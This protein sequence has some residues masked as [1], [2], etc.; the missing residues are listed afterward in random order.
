MEFATLSRVMEILIN[1]AKS[2]IPDTKTSFPLTGIA[3]EVRQNIDREIDAME[4]AAQAVKEHT[5]KSLSD[6]RQR[7]NQFAP[8]HRLPPELLSEI[9]KLVMFSDSYF[10]MKTPHLRRHT[11]SSVSRMWRRVVEENPMLWTDITPI[12][13]SFVDRL[14][15]R[16]KKAPINIR[17]PSDDTEEASENG[18]EGPSEEEGEETRGPMTAADYAARVTPHTHRWQKC[19]LSISSP[20]QFELFLQAPAPKLEYLTLYSDASSFHHDN[21][22]GMH[23][24]D[25][26][27]FAENTPGLRSVS[28]GGVYISLTSR[29]YHN[30]VDLEF[31]WVKFDQTGAIQQ[32]LAILDSSPRLENLRFWSVEFPPP[33]EIAATRTDA[34]QLSCLCRAYFSNTTRELVNAILSNIATP[35]TSAV[36]LD[37]APGDS[38]ESV[39][40]RRSPSLPYRLQ[41]LL[42]ED[43]KLDINSSYFHRGEI[44]CRLT[45]VKL[46]E[47]TTD[48][49]P[50]FEAAIKMA[51]ITD[52]TLSRVSCRSHFHRQ[53]CRVPC[54]PAA[55][56]A[57]RTQDLH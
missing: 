40:P 26:P 16:S 43:L 23:R 1:E 29:I 54:A 30:L 8:I 52:F 11:L 45:G 50:T 14:L 42:F 31:A 15:S 55:R 47:S 17:F 36:S 34:I 4:L 18:S 12:S 51:S 33:T 49:T 20:H 32:L 35:P 19:Q 27:V 22:N 53:L 13:G 24:F 21:F 28:L 3:D 57:P 25:Y 9:F 39:L 2:H 46:D 6:L 56:P 38:L 48:L 7:R 37:F 5:S 44:T 41:N 10:G